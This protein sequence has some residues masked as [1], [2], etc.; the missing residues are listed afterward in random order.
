MLGKS[1]K[2]IPVMV[3]GVIINKKKYSFMKYLC[4]LMIV[5]GVGLFLYKDSPSSKARSSD[6]SFKLFDTIGLGELLVVS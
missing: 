3:L 1:A 2:P 4:I 6:E 5:C